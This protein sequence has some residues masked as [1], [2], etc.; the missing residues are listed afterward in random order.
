MS[1]RLAVP[2]YQGA[3]RRTWPTAVRAAAPW[4]VPPVGLALGVAAL[5]ATS[6]AG[7]GSLGLVDV[8]PLAMYGAL[9][10]VTAGFFAVVFFASEIRPLLLALHLVVFT[11]LL[12]GAATL[13]E[14]LPRFV[15]A[16]LH[17]GF[18]DYIARTGHTLPA[19]DARFSWPGFF[20]LAAMATRAAVLRDAMP[21]LGWTPVVLNLF[22][23]AVVYRVARATAVT[24]RGAW[25][26]AWLF[27]PADWVGQD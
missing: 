25:L 8:L 4:A 16:W 17:V 13:V 9:A 21:L 23:A 7:I 19:L 1:G 3:A 11:V 14:P 6:P 10:L 26:A 24:A 18:A 27:I 12:H 15:P 2:A 20:A 22:L 5:R